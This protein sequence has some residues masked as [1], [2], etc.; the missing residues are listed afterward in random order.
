M[1]T[2]NKYYRKHLLLF[3]D[4][5]FCQ[6]KMLCQMLLNESNLTNE[7]DC[8]VS[9]QPPASSFDPLIPCTCPVSVN[10]LGTYVASCHSDGNAGFSKQYQVNI[11]TVNC[12]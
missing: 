1:Q 7:E 11:K 3:V 12:L 9:L 4:C 2:V 6:L 10:E 5:Y 8:S